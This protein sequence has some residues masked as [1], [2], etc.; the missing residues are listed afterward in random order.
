M[1]ATD[2]FQE[3]KDGVAA[4]NAFGRL[5]QGF[6]GLGLVV[7]VAALGVLSFRAVVERRHS[8]GMMRAVGYKSRMIQTQFLIESVFITVLGSLLGL[9][10]GAWLSWLLVDSF[11]ETSGDV[12]YVV[13]WATVGVI[14]LIALVASLATTFI[15]AR[16]ASKIYP[17]EALRYE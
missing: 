17:S 14:L 7:G 16:Q 11:R 3:I 9:G 15:P 2:T 4:N 13:P 5:F 1:E 8:I 12:K 6:M 10:L